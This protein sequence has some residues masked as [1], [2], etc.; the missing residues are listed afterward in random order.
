M[1]D[2]ELLG[3]SENATKEEIKK[4][5][6]KKA[7]ELHP[8]RGGDAKMFKDLQKA[9]E[10]LVNE[11]PSMTIYTTH[12]PDINQ[13]YVYTYKEPDGRFTT[14]YTYNKEEYDMLT[15]MRGPSL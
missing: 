10:N 7:L 1:N 11:K 2:Y 12:Q 15:K 5:Y 3:I 9:Y 6:R 8:D 14:I 13:S 4:A